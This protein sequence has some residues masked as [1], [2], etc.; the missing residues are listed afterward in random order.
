MTNDKDNNKKASPKGSPRSAA[1]LAAVQAVYQ[2]GMSDEPNTTLVIDEYRRHR[3]G[4]EVDGDL[5]NDAD[6]ILFADVLEGSWNRREELEAL[7]VP[8]LNKDW[9]LDRL[10]RL[11]YAVLLSGCYELAARPDVPTPVII[12]EYIDVMHAFYERQEVAFVNGVLDK[13]AKAVRT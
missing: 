10:E 4:H 12:N 11:I 5:Y 9:S 2:L 6:S 7:I 8:A 1:R 3:L 13:I